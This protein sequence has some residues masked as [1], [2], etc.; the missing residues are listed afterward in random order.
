MANTHVYYREL[1]FIIEDELTQCYVR[2]EAINDAPIGVT[3]WH[4][5]TFPKSKPI[6]KIISYMVT[7]KG[8]PMMWPLNAPPR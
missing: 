6:N 5:K 4:H 8:A 7:R 3:G 1:R 2:L